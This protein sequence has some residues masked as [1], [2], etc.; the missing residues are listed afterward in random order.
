MRSDRFVIQPATAADSAEILCLLEENVFPGNV[1]LIYTRRPDAYRSFMAE[2]KEAHLLV[3]RDT[4]EGRIA[5]LAH[6][7]RVLHRSS[8]EKVVSFGALAGSTWR[9]VSVLPSAYRPIIEQFVRRV[10]LPTAILGQ[11]PGQRC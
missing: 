5:G 11:P 10:R 6:D 4:Q 7:S 3:C 9:T 2:G 8:P 1:S